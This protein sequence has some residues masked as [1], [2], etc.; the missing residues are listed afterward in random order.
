[1]LRARKRSD[2]ERKRGD[3]ERGD[4]E[5]SDNER[6]DKECLSLVASSIITLIHGV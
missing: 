6:S 5:R 2:N 3:N 4:N 1:M